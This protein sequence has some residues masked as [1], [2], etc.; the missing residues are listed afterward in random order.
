MDIYMGEGQISVVESAYYLGC[1]FS[2]SQQGSTTHYLRMISE[3]KVAFN[4]FTKLIIGSQFGCRVAA[5]SL[6]AHATVVPKLL[7]GLSVHYPGKDTLK[8]MTSCLCYVGRM[9]LNSY[10]TDS[11]SKILSYLGW[12]TIEDSFARRRLKFYFKMMFSENS[13][14]SS[15]ASFVSSGTFPLNKKSWWKETKRAFTVALSNGWIS[16]VVND[17]LGDTEWCSRRMDELNRSGGRP[18]ANV[19]V[20]SCPETAHYSFIFYRNHFGPNDKK[21]QRRKAGLDTYL[22]CYLCGLPNSDHP[23]HLVN[24]PCSDIVE[25]IINDLTSADLLSDWSHRR[26]SGTLLMEPDALQS[27]TAPQLILFGAVHKRLWLARRAARLRSIA[28]Q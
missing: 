23:T 7:Y 15:L 5:G 14:L 22:P 19:M 26:V 18:T 17:R 27:A 16:E 4:R 20:K 12:E 10:N 6:L 28:A 11:N 1:L 21:N 24:G 3:V 2:S 13:L 9:V 8:K 25:S